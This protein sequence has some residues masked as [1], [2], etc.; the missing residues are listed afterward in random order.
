MKA[1][2]LHQPF[3]SLIANGT[4]TIETRSWAPP[5]GLI[6]E[7]IAIHAAKAL[8]RT[9]RA[10]CIHFTPGAKRAMAYPHYCIACFGEGPIACGH[11]PLGVVVATAVIGCV[12]QVLSQPPANPDFV[13]VEHFRTS[14]G[15]K[16]GFADIRSD[17]YGD[18]TNGRWLWF[19]DGIEREDPPALAKGQQGFWNWEPPRA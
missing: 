17:P 10:H 19:L 3:A 16:G 15:Y 18:F 13:H 7:R 14:Q 2:T 1:I 12:G 9:V 11:Y 8:D 6:G 4:K 5:Q